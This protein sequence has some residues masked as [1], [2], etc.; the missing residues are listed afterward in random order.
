MADGMRLENDLCDVHGNL[1]AR[2]HPRFIDL[3][4]AAGSR[5]SFGILREGRHP[6]ALFP[7]N[8]FPV[9]ETGMRPR[10]NRRSERDCHT[11]PRVPQFERV[12]CMNAQHPIPRRNGF[13]LIEVLVSLGLCALLAATTASAVAFA[14]RSEQSAERDGD[15]SLMLQRLYAAQRL[16]P[17]SPPDPP[18]NWRI[19]RAVDIVPYSE[20]LHREWHVIAIAARRQEIPPFRIRILDDTP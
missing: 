11:P 4:T 14:A 10:G 18:N 12:H 16:R 7:E 17:D 20:Q 19:D 5:R 1:A 9:N 6:A 15:A 8:G 2:A 3:Q 13:S